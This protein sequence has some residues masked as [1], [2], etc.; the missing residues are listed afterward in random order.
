M[1]SISQL[2][3]PTAP[4]GLLCLQFNDDSCPPCVCTFYL[5]VFGCLL[6]LPLFFSCPPSKKRQEKQQQLSWWGTPFQCNAECLTATVSFAKRA[7]N[8]LLLF[9]FIFIIFC[10][11]F[12]F[13]LD[14]NARFLFARLFVRR[15]QKFFRFGAMSF[16]LARVLHYNFEAK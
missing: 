9:Y 5:F 14:F 12:F 13:C 6:F 8:T 10:F 4:N 15:P 3:L 1:H 2:L 7:E 11:S 16:D